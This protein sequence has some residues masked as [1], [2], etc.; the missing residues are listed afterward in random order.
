MSGKRLL[1]A[2]ALFKAS[3]AVASNHIRLRS[4]ELDTYSKTSSLAKLLRDRAHQ[5][6][7]TLEAASPTARH[8][9]RSSV[10]FSTDTGVSEKSSANGPVPNREDGYGLQG[11]TTKKDGL[12]QDHFYERSV[13]NASIQPA[14]DKD[15]K[16]KQ[17]AAQ[18]NPLPD[19]TVP[20]A[21]ASLPGSNGGGEVFSGVQQ[22][23][24]VKEPVSD[25]EK[26]G[27]NP[28]VSG[29]SSIPTPSRTATPLSADHARDLQRQSERQIPSR[30]AEPPSKDSPDVDV[31]SA[32]GEE[33]RVDQ[34]K[35][36]YYTPPSQTSPVLSSLPRVKVPK[37][38]ENAQEGDEHVP[39][40]GI[41]QDVYYAASSTSRSHKLPETQAVPQQDSLPEDM[42][43]EIFHSPRVARILSKGTRRNGET[44]D[45]HP[46]GP[47]LASLKQSK[48]AKDTDE[49]AHSER[50]PNKDSDISS[51]SVKKD[52]GEIHQLA[53]DIAE[54]ADSSTSAAPK[55]NFYVF[56]QT[57]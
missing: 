42:Y 15:L 3:R 45:L 43:G 28:Q 26:P 32:E 41:N 20:P 48:A 9:E 31:A 6:T 36:V 23:V 10:Q 40:Q 52:E 12:D 2:V 29:R 7:S 22:H 54:N 51:Q 19:G 44:E 46:Q 25:S 11:S 27:L 1:D 57:T 56:V 13:D 14:P 49:E 38:T 4:Q 17:E 35:D 16:L 37:K 33:L 18:A 34:E 39:D 30:P 50:A 47:E 8:Y 55:V 21:G 5:V 53:A 24:P